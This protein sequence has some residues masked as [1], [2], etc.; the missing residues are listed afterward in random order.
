MPRRD[1]FKRTVAT[2]ITVAALSG[3]ACTQSD[4]TKE[5]LKLISLEEALPAPAG[6]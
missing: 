1:F 5:R 4:P 3:T 6:K 2:G